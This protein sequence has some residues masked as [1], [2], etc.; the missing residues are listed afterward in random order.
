MKHIGTKEKLLD[1]S[2]LLGAAIAIL[3]SAFMGFM[4]NCESMPEKTFRLHIMANSDSLYDQRI[5]LMLRD[6][7]LKKFGELFSDCGSKQEAKRLAESR[8]EE[9]EQEANDFLASKGIS[10]TAECSV[11]ISGFPTRKYGDYTRSE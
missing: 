3:I 11:G 10:C 4:Q 9:I 1:I 7:I 6:D 8:L 2:M 5:K